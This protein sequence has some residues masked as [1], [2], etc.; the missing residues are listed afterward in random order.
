MGPF[1][2]KMETRHLRDTDMKKLVHIFYSVPQD[3]SDAK[4]AR[5]CRHTKEDIHYLPRRLR[6]TH[7]SLHA[8]SLCSTHKGL[9]DHLIK[10]IWSWLLHELGGTIGQFLYPVI[11]CGRLSA[12]E[13][14]EARQLEPV[15]Q[16]WRRD[17][18]QA[19]ATPPSHEPI[20]RDTRWAYQANKC[21]ACILGRIGSDPDVLFALFAG[22]VGRFSTRTLV[23]AEALGSTDAWEK[24][25]SKR[26]RFVKYWLRTIKDGDAAVFLAGTL[27]MKMRR[28]RREWMEEQ[29][30]IHYEQQ[31]SLIRPSLNSNSD[32]TEEK[33][34]SIDQ[35]IGPVPRPADVKRF[36]PASHLGFN[37]SPSP[38][39][40]VQQPALLGPPARQP[41]P[42][43]QPTTALPIRPPSASS[44]DTVRLPRSPVR[45]DSTQHLRPAPLQP[46]PKQAPVCQPRF[47]T[48]SPIPEGYAPI[49]DRSGR[50]NPT[51]SEYAGSVRTVWRPT[52]YTPSP[53][54]QPALGL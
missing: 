22:M 42:I 46:R 43:R 16:M 15:S 45:A 11:M 6:A 8:T 13:E 9:D 20:H 54:F 26:I 50:A 14:L 40:A 18:N 33:R 12:T 5:H 10:E 44:D 48:T 29:Q 37:I 2:K 28:V 25:R 41:L 32:R 31:L 36:S 17:Y 53:L 30:R 21:A 7:F 51:E 35:K 23:N 24:T 49:W 34:D 27:G 47:P 39:H 52:P 1:S 4:K 3:A 19:A 38:T